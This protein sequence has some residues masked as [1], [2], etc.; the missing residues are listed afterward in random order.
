MCFE[1]CRNSARACKAE[2]P[3][4]QR[5]GEDHTNCDC[6]DVHH[7]WCPNIPYVCQSGKQENGVPYYILYH[8]CHMK[9]S[10]HNGISC[11]S[12]QVQSVSSLQCTMK[13]SLI[14]ILQFSCVQH[15]MGEIDI[16]KLVHI[17]TVW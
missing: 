13:C 9:V 5:I 15:H 10:I 12:L 14:A 11:V 3:R 4:V 7:L 8:M 17:T 6:S 16:L 2:A 1:A